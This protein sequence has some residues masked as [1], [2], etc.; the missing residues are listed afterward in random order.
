LFARLRRHGR[1]LHADRAAGTVFGQGLGR[2]FDRAPAEAESL[3]TDFLGGTETIKK[4]WA[5]TQNLC[6]LFDAQ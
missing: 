3:V 5:H 4:G 1:L 2:D 6:C